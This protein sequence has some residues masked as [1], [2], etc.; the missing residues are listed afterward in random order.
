MKKIASFHT[1]L[2]YLLLKIINNRF[3][4]KD[5]YLIT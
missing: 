1:I 2:K 4:N 5:I 3:N